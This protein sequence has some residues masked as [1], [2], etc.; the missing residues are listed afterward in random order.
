MRRRFVSSLAMFLAAFA[1]PG[2][3]PAAAPSQTPTFHGDVAAIVHKHCASCHRPGEVA[4]FSLL[5]YED[6]AKRAEHVADI[7]ARRV[8][9]PWKPL[10]GHASFLGERKLIDAEVKTIRAW[11]DAGAPEGDVA[12][13]VA[14]PTFTSSW[15]LGEP[16]LVLTVAEPVAIPADGRDV[17]MNV[18]LPL[19]VP[20]G[21]FLKAAEFRPGNP[22]VVHHAVLSIDE[23]GEARKRDEAW[24]GQ[25]FVAVSPPGRFL[26][27]TLAVWTPGRM[28]LALPEGIAMPWP[29]EADLV[30]NLHLH[31]SG[32]PETDQSSVGFYFT[33]EP[34]RHSLIDLTLIDTK[35]NIEPGD[36][37][38][39]TR[40]E[41]TLPIDCEVLTIFPHMH[42]IG[43]EIDVTATLPDGK[44]KTLLRIDDWDFNWQDMYQFEPPVRLPKGT[45]VVLTA[46]HDNSADNPHNPKSPPERVRWGEQTFN[47]MSIAFLSLTPAKEDDLA[48]IRGATKGFRLGIRPPG[49]KSVPALAA[50]P[51]QT[52][53]L[54]TEQAKTQAEA[55][56]KKADANGDGKLTAL[57]I[58]RGVE[59]RAS[60][61]EVARHLDKFDTNGDKQLNVDEAAAVM[62]ALARR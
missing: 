35:I 31:P 6:V 53:P 60:E 16:D 13:R 41:T 11:A 23:R 58:S 47:E 20:T 27:G 12:R 34:P 4:P 8:M 54:T 18:I 43:K 3:S 22:R 17:Y 36:K 42:M 61:E 33:D 25:G 9:P 38:F 14:P 55:F 56:M 62:K 7:T 46:M 40:D 45:K 5:S 24:P 44:T 32:K 48:T 10:A 15:Q 51:K 29:A 21:K 49:T 59:G 50:K 39:R 30:L 19:K 52:M 28:P 26:P 57:E 1:A 37:T 2:V